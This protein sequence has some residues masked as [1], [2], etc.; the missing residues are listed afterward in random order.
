MGLFVCLFVWKSI[1]FIGPLNRLYIGFS[2]AAGVKAS[3][4][5]LRTDGTGTGTGR[6]TRTNHWKC[7]P[8]RDS[9]VVTSLFITLSVG[10]SSPQTTCVRVST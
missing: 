3:I 1:V 8:V 9:R 4:L 7:P 6:I 5:V 10:K 2:K